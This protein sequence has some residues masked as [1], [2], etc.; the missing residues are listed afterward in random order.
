AELLGS[1]PAPKQPTAPARGSAFRRVTE[2]DQDRA[3]EAFADWLYRQPDFSEELVDDEI[4][5]FDEVITHAE[6]AKLDVRIAAHVARLVGML[7]DEF[8]EDP[9]LLD[10]LDH[11]VHFRLESGVD[12]AGWETAHDAVEELIADGDPMVHAIATALER[13]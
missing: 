9:V 6:S 12:P 4:D 7:E 3:L 2:S 5:A 8:D 10:A 1:A 11:Y 13:G